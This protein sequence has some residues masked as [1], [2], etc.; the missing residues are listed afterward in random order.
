MTSLDADGELQQAQRS[1]AI[2]D[3]RGLLGDFLPHRM[4]G[5]TLYLTQNR[6]SAYFFTG[7]EE[8]TWKPGL[9]R[10]AAYT[11][12]AGNYVQMPAASTDRRL[13]L[14]YI[15]FTW[16]PRVGLKPAG[17]IEVEWIEAGAPE[18]ITISIPI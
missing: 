16:F 18:R 8:D 12:P 9:P 4:V 13:A 1:Q 17:N 6:S 3:L 14:D 10:L 11:L 7:V 15:Y 2:A 5:A